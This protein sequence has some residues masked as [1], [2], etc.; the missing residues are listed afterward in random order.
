M[1]KERKMINQL[2]CC[3]HLLS[4]WQVLVRGDG[5]QDQAIW[6]ELLQTRD[7]WVCVS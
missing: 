2:T 4:I 7:D 6:F 1:S 3:E 5:V